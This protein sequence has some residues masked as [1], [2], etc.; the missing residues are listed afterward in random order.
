[1]SHDLCL[2]A[3]S[4]EFPLVGHPD[5]DALG[6]TQVFCGNAAPI[7]EWYEQHCRN[8]GR[9]AIDWEGHAYLECSCLRENDYYTPP[10]EWASPDPVTRHIAMINAFLAFAPGAKFGAD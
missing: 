10:P 9:A 6:R 2:F 5:A 1:V 4:G 8:L 3:S 7:I